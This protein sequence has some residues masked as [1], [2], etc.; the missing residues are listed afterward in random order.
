MIPSHLEWRR[1]GKWRW[2]PFL[3][4]NKLETLL[5]SRK[6]PDE[7][8]PLQIQMNSRIKFRLLR[9]VIISVDLDMQTVSRWQWDGVLR[10][11]AATVDSVEWVSVVRHDAVYQSN[12]RTRLN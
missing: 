10:V 12:Q 1:P 3:W 4:L 5:I 11:E 7:S 2:S 8:G 6:E 9:H